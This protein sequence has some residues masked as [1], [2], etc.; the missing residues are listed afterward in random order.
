MKTIITV[1]LIV[2]ALGCTR[3]TGVVTLE[4]THIR[5]IAE[6]A[7]QKQTNVTYSV[8]EMEFNSIVTFSCPRSDL[9]T[10]TVAY[11]V[12]KTKQPVESDPSLVS[13]V[14]V[15]VVLD[16][17]GKV[18]AVIQKRETFGSVLLQKYEQERYGKDAN[19]Q[20]HHY[21]ETRGGSPQG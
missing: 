16:M 9:D 17:Q 15:R 21:S 8:K 4:Q 20:Q 12:P 7:M 14:G 3:D 13:I 5:Q 10:I 19:N 11:T 18:H 2:T 1:I 6:T